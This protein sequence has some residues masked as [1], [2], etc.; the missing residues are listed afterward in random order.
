MNKYNTKN[1]TKLKK[2]RKCKRRLLAN[3][4]HFRSHKGYKDG[5][6]STCKE[7]RGVNFTKYLE[8]KEG[9]KECNKC[10]REL[11]AD[12]D[13][14]VTSKRHWLGVSGT[15]KEC[16]GRS[17]TNHLKIKVKTG[18]KK[19]TE[20]E[21]QYPA[22]LEYFHS[23]KGE[24][25]NADGL[26][27]SCKKCKNKKDKKY[28][29]ENKEK[30]SKYDKRYYRENKEKRRKQHKEWAKKNKD[31][32]VAITQR[33]NAR[34]KK[35]PNDFTV[36]DWKYTKKHFGYE[37]SYCGVSEKEVIDNREQKLEQ[38]HFVPLS[39]GGAYTKDNIIPSCKSCNSSKGN[40]SFGDWYPNQSFY[41]EEREVRILDYLGRK[42]SVGQSTLF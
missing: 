27:A 39:E 18:Y 8:V 25:S 4:D 10:K 3:L 5:M 21:E 36:D 32:V 31:L 16:Q 34:A 13:H 19:C 26:Y 6:E 1:D 2:C 7:C 35:L 20:C 33:R 29:R 24:H 23:D 38:E 37:C 17:F 22:T 9:Y 15:C 40:K 28:Y 12:T 41:S 11:P 30:I 14:Y 42:S